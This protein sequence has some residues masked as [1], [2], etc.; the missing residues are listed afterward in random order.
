[1]A[2]LVAMCHREAGKT[3]RD[4]KKSRDYQ[5]DKSF[6]RTIAKTEY[7][8]TPIEISP[9]TTASSL[10]VCCF[11]SINHAVSHEAKNSITSKTEKH[12]YSIA[13]IVNK[14]TK[15]NDTNC[16]GETN[17]GLNKTLDCT[18]SIRTHLQMP[19]LL[20]RS[21]RMMNA[22]EVVIRATKQPQKILFFFLLMIS[23]VVVW[24]EVL[25]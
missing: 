23:R 25:I 2:E 4:G 6:D 22:I 14:E 10:Q 24:V 20:I 16:K 13:N 5:V 18:L 7:H 17:S 19:L 21:A 3:I 9:G 8:R 12:R 11:N 1:M 15:E